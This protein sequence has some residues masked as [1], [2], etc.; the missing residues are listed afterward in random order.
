M[1]AE[2][3]FVIMIGFLMLAMFVG[4]WVFVSLGLTG[5]LGLFLMN[6]AQ[7]N[8]VAVQV[9]GTLNSPTLSAG[10]LFLFMGEIILR[11]GV[12]TQT[13]LGLSKILAALP[14]GLLHTNVVSCAMFAA[15][16]GSSVATAATIGTVAIPDQKAL[17]YNRRLLLGSIAGAGSLGILIPPSINMI[18]Y[19]AWVEASIGRL[20]AGGVIPGIIMALLFS[21]YLAIRVSM[22]PSLAPSLPSTWRE[23]LVS[24]K[25]LVP[26]SVLI[27]FIF[28]GIFSGIM[29]PTET[30][31]LGAAAAVVIAAALG[32]FSWRLVYDS[33]VSA[34]GVSS[35]ILL[36]MG[37]ASIAA[38][39]MTVGG[40]PSR[41]VEW[42]AKSGLSNQQVLLIIYLIYLLLGCIMEGISMMMVTL[43]FVL[44]I[45]LALKIDL[46]WFGIVLIVLTE[47]GMLTPPLG[48][49]LYVALGLDKEAK[50]ED[51]VR[52][53]VPFLFL[54]GVVLALLTAYPNLALFLPNLFFGPQ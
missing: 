48:V 17:G 51:A 41:M 40:M 19:G 37:S 30:A 39:A 43:P 13:Y 24:L 50:F 23:K 22:N 6:P 25:D 15:I 29:T 26:I 35:M 34:L 45:L 7:L 11:S 8:M 44:P 9:W 12:S 46:V 32:R 3:I 49:T 52:G 42:V 36:I 21:I 5:I 38:Y 10:P 27:V 18:I 53:I 2:A 47:M 28:Y 1:S 14:G 16:S 4:N 33:A 31:A 20:F 54:Q